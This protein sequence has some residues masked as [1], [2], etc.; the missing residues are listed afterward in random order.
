MQTQKFIIVTND[1]GGVTKT[2]TA[3][4][5]AAY[6]SNHG[7]TVLIDGDPNRSATEWAA[8]GALPFTVVDLA[9]GIYQA[10]NFE[11]IVI[12]TEA[13]PGSSDIESL[14][15]G[16]DLLVIPT[17]AATLDSKVTARTLGTMNEIA[18]GKFRVLIAKAPPYPQKDA[19]QLREE[20]NKAG[21]PLF[22]TDIPAL[23]A[24]EH[25]AAA[26][27]PVS[28]IKHKDSQRA[29]AAYEAVGEQ[30]LQILRGE[31]VHAAAAE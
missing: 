20:L 3:F 28:D 13:R 8:T 26:G 6:L 14:A 23:K 16:C 19:L 18:P 7:R 10:R 12:D 21:I 24:F 15:K 25:A 29:W 4:H 22:D 9:E 5:L 30:I 17:V 31:A 11:F 27:L 2:T 1:K